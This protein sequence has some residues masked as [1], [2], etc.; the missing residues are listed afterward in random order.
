MLQGQG[1]AF[2]IARGE[3]IR[4]APAAAM[5][6]R[7]Y[8]VDHMCCVQAKARRHLGLTCAAAIEGPA[9]LQQLG[10][11]ST[12]DGAV[13]PTTAQQRCVGG[14]DDGVH[15]EPGDVALDGGEGCNAVVFLKKVVD[16]VYLW[17]L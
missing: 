9:G 13:H 5:P 1:D 4:L 7:T 6:H 8:R 12:M 16:L 10:T 17:N 15:L 2:S 11:S 14:I 3:Q